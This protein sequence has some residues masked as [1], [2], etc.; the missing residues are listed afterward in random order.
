MKMPA[1]FTNMPRTSLL[2]RPQRVLPTCPAR[3]LRRARSSPTSS[4]AAAAE[5]AAATCRTL[6][7]TAAIVLSEQLLK[8][9]KGT[10][11]G[12]AVS[13]K[14]RA[15]VDMIVDELE[16][17]Y[18]ESGVRFFEQLIEHRSM[19]QS[20]R[21]L[22][23][24][25]RAGRLLMPVVTGRLRRPIQGR[26]LLFLVRALCS[27]CCGFLALILLTYHGTGNAGRTRV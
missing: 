2:Q 4:R 13:E 10:D 9:V 25:L 16:T 26:T 24:A 23:R 3:L 5:T 1:G 27:T 20:I 17:R 7:N 18:A 11:S 14:T 15:A 12:A 6:E 22:A 21:W 8:F 19:G